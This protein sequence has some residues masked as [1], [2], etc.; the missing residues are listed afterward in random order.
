M[1][2]HRIVGA[3]FHRKVI[4]LSVHRAGS[5]VLSHLTSGDIN[6]SEDASQEER[7]APLTGHYQKGGSPRDSSTK[8]RGTPPLGAWSMTA[9]HAGQTAWSASPLGCASGRGADHIEK[10]LGLGA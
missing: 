1:I 5:G 9:F 10:R 7:T 2:R 4:D 3:P 8:T 6:C